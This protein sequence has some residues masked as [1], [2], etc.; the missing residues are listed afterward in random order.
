MKTYAQHRVH[1]TLMVSVFAANTS[2]NRALLI[3]LTK[4]AM[5]D[6]QPSKSGH[7]VL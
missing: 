1:D 7:I 2:E 4:K 3:N 6:L 5:V